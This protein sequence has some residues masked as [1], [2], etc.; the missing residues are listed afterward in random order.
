MERTAVDW[1]GEG[2]DSPRSFARCSPG[3]NTYVAASDEREERVDKTPIAD[4]LR[5]PA[6]S[7]AAGCPA[8][9]DELPSVLEDGTDRFVDR[10]PEDG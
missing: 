4:S 1:N 2:M 3:H 7:Q 8:N 6:G 5:P 10:P 9:L